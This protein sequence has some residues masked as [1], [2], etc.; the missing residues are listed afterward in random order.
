[1]L[2]CKAKESNISGNIQGG[3]LSGN[4]QESAIEA[5]STNPNTQLQSSN[6][7]NNPISASS[8]EDNMN[9]DTAEKIIEILIS[10][11]LASTKHQQNID[12][13]CNIYL[14]LTLILLKLSVLIEIEN[15]IFMLEKKKHKL[16]F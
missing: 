9:I 3:K 1:M 13:S 12:N 15:Q 5:I 16:H 6:E 10:K 8:I 14:M 4:T 11:A 2:L 7:S